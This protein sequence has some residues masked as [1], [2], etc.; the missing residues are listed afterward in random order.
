MRTTT[1]SR[2][3]VRTT[4]V[5]DCRCRSPAG[6]HYPYSFIEWYNPA[7]DVATTVLGGPAGGGYVTDAILLP[8]S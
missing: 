3:T 7:A 6:A 1:R 2:L 5:H 4:L 8:A